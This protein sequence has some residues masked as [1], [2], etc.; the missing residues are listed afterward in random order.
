MDGEKPVFVSVRIM[1]DIL[2]VPGH[3]VLQVFES[4]PAK[5]EK[6]CPRQSRAGKSNRVLI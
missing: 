1:P 5:V 3:G 6:V 2:H 4:D